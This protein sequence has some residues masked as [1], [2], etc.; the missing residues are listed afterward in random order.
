MVLDPSGVSLPP[1][2]HIPDTC[3]V[4][5]DRR[6]VKVVSDALVIGDSMARQFLTT[7][8]HLNRR[9][10]VPP[11]LDFGG[12]D[13]WTYEPHAS[14][15]PGRSVDR[16]RKLHKNEPVVLGP[17]SMVLSFQTCASG[18]NLTRLLHELGGFRPARVILFAPVYWHGRGRCRP[19]TWS[20]WA[21]ELLAR[22]SGTRPPGFRG[23][24]HLV[25]PPLGNARGTHNITTALDEIVRPRWTIGNIYP[26]DE[27]VAT[28]S[29]DRSSYTNW[30][31][32]CC[33]SHT[34][35]N[36][37]HFSGTRD[38]RCAETVNTQLLTRLAKGSDVLSGPAGKTGHQGLFGWDR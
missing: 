4:A 21:W 23:P 27:G 37:L 6:V 22:A 36:S 33:L 15:A 24:I 13:D 17:S 19:H 16:L 29:R 3:F 1:E 5:G 2:C 10:G 18:I 28:W 8:V 20:E 14:H 30:H 12:S 11:V 9:G 38:G 25:V 32:V 26:M 35:N 34:K 31:T 7:C